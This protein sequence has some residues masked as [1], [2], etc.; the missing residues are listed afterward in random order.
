MY[1]CMNM[2]IFSVYFSALFANGACTFN[3]ILW[4]DH[5]CI[6]SG[7][8]FGVCDNNYNFICCIILLEIIP[9]SY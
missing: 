2:F 4:S 6:F 1:V 8:V 3:L 5:L 7:S 9:C